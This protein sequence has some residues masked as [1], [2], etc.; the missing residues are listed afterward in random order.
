MNTKKIAGIF[1]LLIFA[2]IVWFAYGKEKSAN[3]EKASKNI[4]VRVVEVE[5][6]ALSFPVHTS[7]TLSSKAEMQ[8]AF[9]IGG[10]MQRVYVDEGAKVKKGQLLARLDMAEIEAQVRQA[11][12][13]FE[14]AKRDLKRVKNL[15]AD[16]VT[17]LEQLQNSETALEVAESQLNIARFNKKHAQ[18]TAPSNGKI[19]RRFAEANEIISPGRPVFVLG[20]SD[21]DWIIRVSVVD[22]DLVRLQLGDSAEVVFD[23]YNGQKIPAVVSEIGETADLMTGTYEIE[24]RPDKISKKLVS[25]FFA[26]VEIFPGERK[27]YQVIPIEALHEASGLDGYVYALDEQN[28]VRK[29]PIS[30]ARVFDDILAVEGGLENVNAVITDGNAYLQ[31]GALVNVIE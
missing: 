4:N 6:K 14:K 16:S 24:V 18:I 17:T 25:G 3:G 21:R 29:T 27:T 19:L 20:S 1:G 15:Y 9:K 5:E 7:G 30:I 13:A 26:R 2:A 10:V 23:A 12:S 31:D 11:K 22:R 28:Q 8:L